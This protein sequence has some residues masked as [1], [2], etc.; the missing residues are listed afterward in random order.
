MAF[1]ANDERDR[2]NRSRA[3]GHIEHT[4]IKQLNVAAQNYKLF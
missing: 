2:E 1:R 3:N 4:K